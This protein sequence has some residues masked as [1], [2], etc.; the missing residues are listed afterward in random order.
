MK[1]RHHLYLDDELTD[2]LEA[3]AR[4]PGTSKSS[5]VADALRQYLRHRGGNA[6]EQALTK[7][8]DRLSQMAIRNNRDIEL[9]QEAV[10]EFVRIYLLLTGNVSNPDDQMYSIGTK[11]FDAYVERVG[12]GVAQGSRLSRLATD[13][14]DE[15]NSVNRA[16]TGRRA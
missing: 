16:G 1:P 14:T 2:E 6:Q 4:K 11:R 12:K 5:I 3:L 7:R 9:L 13:Q 8:L 10:T 15:P